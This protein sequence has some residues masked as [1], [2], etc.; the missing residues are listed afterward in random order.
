MTVT[1]S[2]AVL[3]G[4]QE[5]LSRGGHIR[6]L[7]ARGRINWNSSSPRPFC[8]LFTQEPSLLGRQLVQGRLAFAQAHPLQVP[9]LLHLQHGI[10]NHVDRLQLTF[11]R[12]PSLYNK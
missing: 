3:F 9:V 12:Q 11:L 7:G 8:W 5:S 6:K 10:A 1:I 4:G 2:R